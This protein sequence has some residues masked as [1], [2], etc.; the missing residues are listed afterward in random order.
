VTRTLTAVLG[1]TAWMTPVNRRRI[2]AACGLTIWMTL[3][4]RFFHVQTDTV[5]HFWSPFMGEQTVWVLVCFGLG[6]AGLVAAAP[7]F[8]GGQPRPYRFLI[9]VAIMTAI[10][11]SSGYFGAEHAVGVTAVFAALFAFRLA[12]SQDRGTLAIA[13][14]ALAVVGP[15]FESLQWQLG[16]FE[17]TKPDVIGVPWWLFPF[18]ANGAW[19]VRELGAL[20]RT[21]TNEP[22]ARIHSVS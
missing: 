13:A 2:F 15:A 5:E 1:L 21:S 19:A 10:Y 11:A 12:M 17:Y 7:R 20:L 3:C 8:A 9:E 18:Y 14:V 22:T 6:A 4:D 16:M